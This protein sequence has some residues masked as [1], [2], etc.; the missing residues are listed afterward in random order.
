MKFVSLILFCFILFACRIQFISISPDNVSIKK[1]EINSITEVE[2]GNPVI[3]RDTGYK[4]KAIRVTKKYTIQTGNIIKELKEG[5]LF[6]NDGYTEEYDL[7]SNIDGQTYGIAIPKKAGTFKAF[8]KLAN[9]VTFYR[10]DIAVDYEEGIQTSVPQK[11]NQIQEFIYNGKVNNAIKFTY[12]EYIND[13]ARP[14]FTQDLQ[15]DLNESKIIG[16]R[17]LRI[18]IIEASNSKIKYKA[19]SSFTN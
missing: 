5:D 16:F 12:R 17:G 13:Y 7:Y 3:S 10:D 14:A 4:Y 2:I 11:R 18:E 6:I 15:Y 8:T 1:P 9:S 19:L